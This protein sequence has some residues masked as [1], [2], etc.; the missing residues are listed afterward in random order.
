MP[1]FVQE[2][3]SIPTNLLRDKYAWPPF[4]ILNTITSEW[5]KR[6]DEWESVIADSTLGREVKRYNA[7]PTNTFSARGA[8]AKDANSVSMFD[9]FLCELMYR[10]FSSEG[11]TVL[12]PFAGGSV[13]GL[14]ASIL[15][16]NYVGI[17]IS[18]SQV[19]TNNEHWN[20]MCTKYT[21]IKGKATW[22]WEDAI[23]I[24]TDYR[25]DMIF[26]C[27]PYYN[28]ERYT[29]EPG[30]LSR[31]KTYDE[32]LEKYASILYKASICLKDNSFFVI[33]VSEVRADQQS[34][35]DSQYLGFV[36]DTI[37]ILRN[38][39]NLKYYNEIILEN[40]IGSLPIRT[41][42]SFD[43]TRKIGRHHQNILVFYKGDLTKIEEKYGKLLV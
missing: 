4:S 6:K 11:D 43:R 19:S 29:N 21:N 23:N 27:P 15:G 20:Y 13:R 30:D 9:P 37:Q 38:K 24:D 34:I 35:A 1:L 5:Q 32:F 40:N 33:V 42:K 7:T 10:W 18:S 25:A 28:I 8:S 22:I 17:D 41:P 31:I 2:K 26:T 16:R 39:C 36:P 3:Q 12:D 14:T